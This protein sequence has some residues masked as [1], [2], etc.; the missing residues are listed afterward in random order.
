[1]ELDRIEKLLEKYFEA[2]ATAAE[3]RELRD[4]FAG[5]GVAPDLETYRPIFAYFSEAKEERYPRQVPLKPR[6]QL[7]RWISVAAVGILMLGLYF[8]NEYREQRKA[9]YAY[10]QT[11]KALGLIAQNLDRGTE[12]VA[13]L[14][15]FEETRQK[16]YKL[17]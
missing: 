12:K 13:R 5:E 3:E 16:I 7:L 6:K 9:E 17:D 4:Y 14:S 8:G 15:E 1:M 2:T 10:Q 11:R